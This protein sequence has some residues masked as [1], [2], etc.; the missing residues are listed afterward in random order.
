MSDEI[1][2]D[3]VRRI[4]NAAERLGCSTKTVQRLMARGEIAFVRITD[5]IP[6]IT[7]SEIDR[8]IAARTMGLHEI[9]AKRSPHRS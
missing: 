2:I 5:R 8:F 3:R 4:K 6:G 9:S 1:R 7:D